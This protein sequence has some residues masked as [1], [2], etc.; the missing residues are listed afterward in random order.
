M[1]KPA[2]YQSSSDDDSSSESEDD[3]KKKTDYSE[4]KIAARIDSDPET[5]EKPAASYSFIDDINKSKL[6]IE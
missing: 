3:M 2:N 4:K 1:K 5:V 6:Y